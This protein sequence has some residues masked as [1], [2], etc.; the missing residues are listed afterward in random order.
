MYQTLFN[1]FTLPQVDKIL[2][3]FVLIQYYSFKKVNK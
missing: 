3:M 2:R 1:A